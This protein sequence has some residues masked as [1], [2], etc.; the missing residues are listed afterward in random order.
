MGSR[1]SRSLRCLLELIPLLPP[2]RALP[3]S[4]VP[5]LRL[6]TR[7][8]PT[9]RMLYPAS[10][11][12]PCICQGGSKQLSHYCFGNRLR[13]RIHHLL[14]EHS[15]P[16]HL[17]ERDGTH[18]FCAG[19]SVSTAGIVAI[20]VQSPTPG[21]GT[22]GA[23]QFE[24]DSASTYDGAP[25]FTTSSATV[26]AGNTATYLVV[27]PFASLGVTATCLNLP[28]GASCSYAA[29]ANTLTITTR[30]TSRW[31]FTTSLWYLPKRSPG[32]QP[33]F[34]LLHFF[35]WPGAGRGR[36]PSGIR[37][38]RLSSL[39]S[40]S[41]Q[42]FLQQQDAAPVPRFGL[43]QYSPNKRRQSRIL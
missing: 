4:V 22:S 43:S 35:L 6:C 10:P 26:T 39:S 25:T 28:V 24:I 32:H 37:C 20:T 36:R 29:A 13:I 7:Q 5:P 3:I 30:P 16:D 42:R 15:T 18:W 8:L 9:L 34:T 12:S 41:K 2:T 14:G 21:D 38:G 23:F 33:F 19:Y 1:A 17:R 11:T 31:A 27:L 40:S